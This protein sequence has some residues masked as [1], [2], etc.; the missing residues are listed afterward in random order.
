MNSV[1]LIGRIVADPELKTLSSGDKK[2]VRF[3]LAVDR[4]ISKEDKEAGKQSAD[5]INCIAWE[6][7]AEII[8]KYVKKGNKLGVTGRI[9]TGSYDREDGSKAYTT[10]IR[11]NRVEL[12]ESKPKDD[13]PEPEYDG[14]EESVKESGTSFE[15]LGEEVVLTDDQLPF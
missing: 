15:S 11:I 8:S 2:Y 1:N 7:S 6:G 13:R 4:G 12:L 9:I 5:F 10:D 3:T 14:V